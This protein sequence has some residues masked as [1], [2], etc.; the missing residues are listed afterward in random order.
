MIP[1]LKGSPVRGDGLAGG[2]RLDQRQHYIAAAHDQSSRSWM[3]LR[4]HAPI[5]PRAWP[6]YPSW[7]VPLRELARVTKSKRFCGSGGASINGLETT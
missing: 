4:G 1:A 7:T 2:A 3:I 6:P 5:E